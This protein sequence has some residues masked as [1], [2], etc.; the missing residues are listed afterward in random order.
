MTDPV[1]PDFSIP[2]GEATSAIEVR[3][4]RFIGYARTVLASGDVRQA[5]DSCRLLHPDASHVTHAFLIGPPNSEVAGCSDD[6]EPKGTAG[7]PMLEVVR[8]SRVVNVLVMV[9][10]YFGGT[11]LGT[12]GLVRAYGECTR[13]TLEALPL[14]PMIVTLGFTTLLPY[15]LH[16]AVV[17]QLNGHGV[18]NLREQYDLQV[19]I[20]GELPEREWDACEQAIRNLSRGKCG[21]RLNG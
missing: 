5:I 9:V 10:R 21:L 16:E 11:K 19:L 8:G 2:A 17:R 7:R 18:R 13:R 6:G 15:D 4:S 12:G 1:Q 14:Q 3:N 20:S